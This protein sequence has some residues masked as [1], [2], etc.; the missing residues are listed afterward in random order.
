MHDHTINTPTGPKRR[1][2][3]HICLAH[4]IGNG[5]EGQQLLSASQLSDDLHL[6]HVCMRQGIGHARMHALNQVH[7]GQRACKGRQ[8]VFIQRKDKKQK[9][10]RH[11]FW[12]RS[13]KV[14]EPA[15]ADRACS[16]KEKTRKRKE[17]ASAFR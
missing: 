9:R 13:M 15:G 3:W 14:K 1:F 7:E 4:L 17:N 16:Y 2:A 10:K 6:G 12:T 5:I 8:G 11:A